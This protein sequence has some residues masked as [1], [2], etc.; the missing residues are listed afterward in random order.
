M[1]LIHSH[2]K[3]YRVVVC[4]I[5]RAR[6]LFRF[7]FSF[8]PYRIFFFGNQKFENS[9]VMEQNRIEARRRIGGHSVCRFFFGFEEKL[10][11]KHKNPGKFDSFFLFSVFS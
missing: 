11:N 1:L 5:D 8:F 10:K 9:A 2:I 7:F 6:E 4:T 3:R